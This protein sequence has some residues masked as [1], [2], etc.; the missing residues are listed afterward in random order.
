MKRMTGFVCPMHPE[1]K[2][3]RPGACPKCG[4][5]LEPAMPARAAAKTIY[6]CP[7]HPQIEQDHPGNCPICGMAL[8]PNERRL[9]QRRGKRRAARYDAAILDRGSAEPA[10]VRRRDGSSVSWRPGVGAGRCVALDAI[11]FKHAGCAV[12]RMAIFPARLAIAC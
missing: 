8:E 1:V 9:S 4:M 7:M 2:S 11:Y 6:T 12:V 3:D 10:G 5:A